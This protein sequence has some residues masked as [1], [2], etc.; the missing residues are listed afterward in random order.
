MLERIDRYE[1]KQRIGVG[2]QAQVYLAED[3]LL[4]KAVAVKIMNQ[5]ASSGNEY[6]T[7]LLSEAQLAAGLSHPNI[8]TVLDFKVEGEYACIIMEYLP[9]SLDKAL[10]ETSPIQ[11]RFI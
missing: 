4:K 2:G 10:N 6:V 11:R 7:A 3:T 8:A 9:N 1:L 5:M